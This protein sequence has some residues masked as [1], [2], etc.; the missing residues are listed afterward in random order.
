MGNEHG[1]PRPFRHSC[2]AG[3]A[4]K[5]WGNVTTEQLHRC[6]VSPRTIRRWV[7][8]GRLH[9]RHRGVYALG[10]RNPAPEARWS[11]ALLA[12]GDG[13]VLSRYVSIALHGVGRPPTTV[14]VAVPR[15]VRKQRGI[16]P[17]SSMPF[18]RDEVVIRNGLSTTSIERT[19]LDLAAIGEPIERLVAE[20][21]A[22]RLT[23]TE[24]LRAY[25]ARRAGARGAARLRRCI[26]GRQTRSKVEGEFARWLEAQ[27]VI[28]PVH[29]RCAL[30]RRWAGGRDRRVRDPRHPSL[31]RGG[32]RARYVSRGRGVPDNPR[33]SPAMAR[34]RTA[35]RS[36]HP[37]C[38]RAALTLLSVSEKN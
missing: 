32:S 21:V 31:L 14:T 36:R 6:G 28:R 17:H 9:P 7:E 25:A 18:E 34:G 15:R 29:P 26:E 4:A 8:D 3:W 2:V 13:S 37:A 38:A 10:H 1:T 30:A 11:A 22:K 33:H 5:Q 23:S 24:R 20:A 35:P 12:C 27:G 16:E 19:L